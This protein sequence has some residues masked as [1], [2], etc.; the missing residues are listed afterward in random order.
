MSEPRRTGTRRA[1]QSG[2]VS[3]QPP[4]P[5]R[6]WYVTSA[7]RVVRQGPGPAEVPF[8]T[9][10]LK[11]LGSAAT[12]CGLPAVNWSILWDLP[13]RQVETVCQAC[14]EI[15]GPGLER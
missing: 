9:G 1:Q 11:E 14:T 15:V 10:H 6:R 4:R 2:Q 5:I 12:A 7:H 8:A 13:L 3:A